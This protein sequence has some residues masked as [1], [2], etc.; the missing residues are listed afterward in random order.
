M[1]NLSKTDWRLFEIVTKVPGGRLGAICTVTEKTVSSGMIFGA[2]PAITGE[3]RFDCVERAI[4]CNRYLP[5]RIIAERV[6]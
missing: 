3:E 6:G 1:G 4:E 5:F 2:R